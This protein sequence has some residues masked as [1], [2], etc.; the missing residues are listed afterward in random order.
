MHLSSLFQ[1]NL[2][3]HLYQFIG[4]EVLFIYFISLSYICDIIVTGYYCDRLQF[5]R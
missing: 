5:K 1:F 4:S 3:K 2:T